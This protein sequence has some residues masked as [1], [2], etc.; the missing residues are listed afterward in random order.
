MALLAV[1]HAAFLLAL[2][3]FRT[4]QSEVLSEPLPLTPESLEVSINSTQQCLYLQWRVHNLTNHQE[5]K[6]VFQI[7]ISRIETSNVIWVENYSTPVTWNQVLHWS[8]ES[9][10]P[11]ECVTHFVR[12]RSRVDDASIPELRSWSNWSSWEEVDAQKSLGQDPLVVFPINKLVEEGS[13]VTICYVSRSPESNISCA[14]EGV[15]IHGERL[16]PNVFAFILNNVRFIRETGTNIY[17]VSPSNMSGTILFVSKVLEE[18]KDFSC[19]T[20]D[21][22]SLNC[23]WDPGHDTTLQYQ[24]SQRYT[25]FESFSGKTKLC[26]HKKWC[27]WQV[28]PDSQETYNLTLIAENQLRRRSVSIFFNLTHRVHP[29]KPFNVFLKN[30]SATNATMTWKVHPVGNY[31]TLLCQV[32]LHGEGK[33]IQQHNVSVK[34]KGQ[35]FLSELEPVT[36]YVTRVRCA[37]SN[38]F[39]KW[40]EWTGQT[41]TTLEAAPSV[42][43]D[44]WRNVKTVLGSH[45]VTLFWRPLSKSHAHGKILFYNVVIENLDNPSS[46]KLLSIPAPANGTELTLDQCSYQ[47]HVTANNSVG[48]SPASIIVIS[49]DPGNKNVEEGRIQGTEDGFSLSWKPQSG[50]VIGYV[51]DWSPQDPRCQLQWKNLGPN[52]TS[53]VIRSDAF[54]PGIRYNF[55]IYEIST[56]RIAYLLERKTGY[57]QELA[58]SENPQ[59]AVS[60][61]TSHSFTLS[62]KD[63][64]TDSQPGFIQGYHVYL[65]PKVEQCHP[66]FEKVALSDDSVCC[67]Y[68]IDNPEQKTFVVE[69][70][71]P[72]SFYEF[73]VTPY[74]SVGEGPHDTFTKVTIPDEY[75]HVLM[76]IIL[77]MSFCLVL[78]MVLCYLTSQWMKDKC[79]PDIPDPY[80]S[81][82]LSLIKYKENH[83]PTIMNVND[84]VPDAI[85]VVNK[86]EGS[87]IQFLGARKSLTEM[88]FTKPA[89]LY[90]LPTE[91]YS[92]PGP[93]ICFENFT[94]NQAASDSGSCGHVPVP[95]KTPPSQLALLTSPENLLKS[96]EQ[97]Y[98]NSSGESPAGENSLNYV[99]QLA[100]P[101]SGDKESL[102]TNPPGPALCS[103]YRTQMAVSL[104]HASPS[105]SENSSLSLVTLLDQ[106][107]HRR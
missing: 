67:Q 59:V 61:L 66:G 27:H 73:L 105:P 23:T 87:R 13:N 37:A 101:M 21:L 91:N 17:C 89:Y 56:E 45:I 20:Q 38:H 31:S 39:W 93:C 53:T 78:L 47:I 72:E 98:V 71:Q 41:F 51:V 43:P 34:V 94:Y 8:W 85:E 32:A 63:Y 75:S 100:S 2:L 42:A 52:T 16:S 107:E 18:P 24:P 69:N 62:W 50:D 44:V 103:E 40:S 55:R 74:T 96:L 57:S 76:R 68:K 82:V 35:Y 97:N 46:V 25:L 64:S 79:Y 4:Y 1:V 65:K 88:E 90:L 49:R 58:P 48:T 95:L 28:A 15:P 77:P 30:I 10:L 99:S 81:S 80:K 12:I 33:V 26:E 19:E 70:L 86:L 84:C 5:L 6:M 3:S 83:H 9:K 7:E 102:P 11:L 92:G 29:M 60:N 22:K 104:G 106:G 36:E 14:M 54:R